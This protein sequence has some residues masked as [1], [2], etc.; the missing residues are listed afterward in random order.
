MKKKV[1]PSILVIGYG[2]ELR[3]DDVVGKKLA[4]IIA[5]WKNPCLRS[6]AVHQLTPELA[7]ELAT[8]DIAIF[9]DAYPA[10]DAKEVEII[11]LEIATSLTLGHICEP[12]ILLAI[13]SAIYGDYPQAWLVKVPGENFE[14]GDRISPFARESMKQALAEINKLIINFKIIAT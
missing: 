12:P 4:D 7:E 2:N 11:P 9:I 5:T 6:L 3:S 10:T 1:N 13:A 14:I 8:V